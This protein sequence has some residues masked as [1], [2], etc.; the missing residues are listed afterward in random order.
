MMRVAF[1]AQALASLALSTT[2]IEPAFAQA[3]VRDAVRPPS[4]ARP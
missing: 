1:L 3:P 2:V 4:S